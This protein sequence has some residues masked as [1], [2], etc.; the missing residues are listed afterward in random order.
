MACDCHIT[1]GASAEGVSNIWGPE[2][3]G[4]FLTQMSG[5]WPGVTQRLDSAGT[6]DEGHPPAPPPCGVGDTRHSG[7]VLEEDTVEAESREWVS[8]D[9]DH[10]RSRMNEPA[11]RSGGLTCAVLDGLKPAQAHLDRRKKNRLHFCFLFLYWLGLVMAHGLSCC[12]MGTLS[13]GVWCLG[14]QQGMEPGCP[15]LGVW[16]LSHWT[17]RDVLR[18]HFLMGVSQSTFQKHIL[19]GIHLVPNRIC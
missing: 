12:G 13:C 3:S 16:S 9:L 11:L 4:G 6:L 15:A 7:E 8:N 10:K 5:V 19:C 2:S 14:P 1:S 17:M 18:L